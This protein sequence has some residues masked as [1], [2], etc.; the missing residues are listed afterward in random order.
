MTTCG[1]DPERE[2]IANA[3]SRPGLRKGQRRHAGL[4]T[5]DKAA[6]LERECDRMRRKLRRTA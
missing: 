5:L 1:M 4:K 6:W 3:Q 2:R